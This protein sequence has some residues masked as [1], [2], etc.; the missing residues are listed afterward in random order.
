MQGNTNQMCPLTFNQGCIF[1]RYMDI[2][3]L[4]NEMGVF[5]SVTDV[6]DVYRD[7]KVSTLIHLESFFPNMPLASLAV[8]FAFLCVAGEG[9]PDRPQPVW[10][11]DR[12]AAVQLG[13]ADIRRNHPAAGQPL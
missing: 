4:F 3:K 10:R 1:D 7:S 6:F 12:L 8:L 5:F 9:A 13:R 11:G 2:T